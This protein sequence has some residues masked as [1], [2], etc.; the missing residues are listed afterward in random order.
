MFVDVAQALK[1]VFQHLESQIFIF[2][3]RC[4]R[5]FYT[6]FMFVLFSQYSFDSKKIIVQTVWAAHK[7]VFLVS[8]TYT[9]FG[10]ARKCWSIYHY[11]IRID[12]FSMFARLFVQC[13]S[14]IIFLQLREYSILFYVQ[15]QICFRCP[16][17][18]A[19]E[20]TVCS[21]NE[22]KISFI[23][24]ICTWILEYYIL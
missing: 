5:Y 3:L 11:L 1:L 17:N 19:D 12:S 22:Y 15:A 7:M 18:D 4:C 14:Y 20:G 8:A 24:C 23:L 9:Y 2:R 13:K 6:L 10:W 21:E 16:E